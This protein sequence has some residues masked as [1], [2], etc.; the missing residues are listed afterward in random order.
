MK[1]CLFQKQ[2]PFGDPKLPQDLL[3]NAIFAWQPLI[4]GDSFNVSLDMSNIASCVS[5]KARFTK[6]TYEVDQKV[7]V[8]V[9]IR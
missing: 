8:E 3:Q 4:A 7:T 1:F 5:T 2:I 9:F 6:K